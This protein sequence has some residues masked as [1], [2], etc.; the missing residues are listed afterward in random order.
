MQD[1][2]E[3]PA[4]SARSS[5]RDC[6]G[7][8]SASS[9]PEHTSVSACLLPPAP[10]PA[11]LG[12]HSPCLQASARGHAA[13]R[14][15]ALS[16]N[17]NTTRAKPHVCHTHPQTPHAAYQ[18]PMHEPTHPHLFSSPRIPSQSSILAAAT[19]ESST[20]RRPTPT[21]LF[22]HAQVPQHIRTRS[23]TYDRI[24]DC[25]GQGANSESRPH[26][27]HITTPAAQVHQTTASMAARLCG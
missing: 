8:F 25:H 22:M 12:A 7:H 9:N 21:A 26:I 15:N 17:T 2:R 4:A 11:L 27:L 23:T 16:P 20:D 19:V 5:A 1:P 13:K 3:V 24:N 18:R 10:A 14:S 6:S